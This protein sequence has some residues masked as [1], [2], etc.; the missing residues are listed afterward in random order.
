MPITKSVKKRVRQA[1]VRY[2]RNKVLSLSIK[3]VIKEFIDSLSKKDKKKS[4][5]LFKSC[6]KMIIKAKNRGILNKN[7]ASRKISSLNA[8]LK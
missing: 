3:K 7:K 5:D 6:Q 8:K 2:E 1:N 4:S